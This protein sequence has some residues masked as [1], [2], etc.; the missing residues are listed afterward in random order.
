[1]L[2]RN[3]HIKCWLLQDVVVDAVT[4]DAVISIKGHFVHEVS[5]QLSLW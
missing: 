1:M 2:M 4:F 3:I 5:D